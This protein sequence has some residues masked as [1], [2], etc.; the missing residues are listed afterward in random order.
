M[1]SPRRTP[2]TSRY[3]KEGAPQFRSEAQRDSDRILYSTAF[4]RLAGITQIASSETGQLLHN[5]LTHSIKVAQV[6]RRLAAKLK[7]DDDVQETTA[8]AALAHD[9]GH[10]P[11]GHIAE[12]VLNEQ[13][14]DW[15]GFE[16][17]A[18][19]FRIVAK[20]AIRSPRYRGLN[21]TAATLN[22]MLKYPWRRGGG[23]AGKEDKW[24]AYGNERLLFD[25]TRQGLPAQEPT[26]EAAIMDW[27]D[28]VTYAV[29]DLEDFYRV[30]LIPL[31]RLRSADER[32]RFVSSFRDSE[33]T[34]GALKS[35]FSDFSEDE[36]LA[37]SEFLVDEVFA[38]AT[39]F[40]G[41]RSERAWIRG[42]TSSLIGRFVDSVTI[43]KG[44]LRIDDDRRAE[45]SVLKELA[46]FY[47]IDSPALTTVQ[48]GQQRVI[49]ELHELYQAA[50]VKP[51]ER[52]LFPEGYRHWLD[53]ATNDRIRHRVATDFVSG[54]TEEMAF[55]LHHRLT[56][57]S[58]GSILDAAALASR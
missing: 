36:L 12:N 56:G 27:A 50:A 4:Q 45:I 24:G 35:K 21:L 31:D 37:A 13:A 25:W 53:V 7:L 26:I 6:A 16:G 14:A 9:L 48:R 19:S 43:T 34:G 52:K 23:P 18:Q 10:P 33:A 29:H 54:L 5:R 15:G 39:R 2:R 8:A 28:D 41:T 38:R 44:K 58:R 57:S 51:S 1:A 11:F 49:C 46:W 40:R 20:L 17:N 32:K 47:I 22:G 42:Q 30:D 55:E 3:K